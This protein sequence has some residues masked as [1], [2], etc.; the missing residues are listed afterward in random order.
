M[1]LTDR[2]KSINQRLLDELA[3]K[4]T[5]ERSTEPKINLTVDNTEISRS[6]NYV[7]TMRDQLIDWEWHSW[8]ALTKKKQNLINLFTFLL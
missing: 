6:K 1:D 2:E 5:L 3:K 8:N 4:L 7:P